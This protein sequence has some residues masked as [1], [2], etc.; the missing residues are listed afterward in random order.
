MTK[1]FHMDSD[2]I[3]LDIPILEEHIPNL[4]IQVD[5]VG[6]AERQSDP[7]DSLTSASG[8]SAAA[9]P[10][11]LPPR[12]AYGSGTL[13]LSIPPIS[14][15]LS[16][17]VTPDESE[18]EPGA[19]TTLSVLVKD[20]DGNPLPD[21][22][23][24]VAV[25]DEAILALTGYRLPDPIQI[26]YSNRSSDLYSVYERTSILLS[27]PLTLANEAAEKGLNLMMDGRG[28][29]GGFVE[30][31]ALPMYS[32][33]APMMDKAAGGQDQISLRTD[34]NPLA[35][36][37]PAARTGL[38]GTARI[39]IQLP[40]NLT[41][42]R[43]MVVAVNP[44]GNKFG[45]AESSLTARLPLMVR[46][47]APRFLN[48]GDRIELPVMIQ[49]QTG[50]SLIVNV[51]AHAVN[52]DLTSPGLQVSVPA[53]DRVEVRFG[54]A[55]AMAGTARIQFAA[56]SGSYSDAASVELPVY[57]PATTESFATYG[58]LD[59]GSFA[60]SVQ[61]PTGV[62]PQFGGLDVT[63]S[64]TALQAL[65]DAVLYLVS[66]PY[67]CSEQLAS[68]ILAISALRDVL[69]AF[70]AEG[71]PSP[72]ELQAAVTRDIQKLA[73]M[74]NSDGG[75]PT[76]RRGF[77][78]NPFNTIHA[79]HA[80]VRAMEKGFT[81]P[82]DMQQNVLIY[83]REVDS[84]Y[85]D[86]YSPE[87]RRTLSAY[88]LYVRNLMGD[89]DAAGAEALLNDA[90]LDGLP[91]QA[92]GWLWPVIDNSLMLD[93]IRV[94]VNNRVVETAG[95]ANFVTSYNDQS[96]LLLSSDRRT[97]AIL[98]DALIGDN[99]DS[100]LIPKLVTGLLENRTRGRWGNTQEN[101]FALLA[102]DRY[103]NTYETETPDFIARLWLGDIYAGSSEFQGRTAELHE[104][105]LPMAYVLSETASGQE[106]LILSKEGSGRLYYR[107]GLSYAPTDLNLDPLEMGFVVR[108]TY[109]AVDDP[110]DVIR[111]AKGV[112]HVR[113]G[114]RVRVLISM[115]ADSRRYHVALVDPLPA[116][117][118]V[119]NPELDVSGSLPDDSSGS[120]YR[121]GW[122]WGPWYEHQNLRDNR[123][124]VFASMLWDGVYKY[125]YFVHATTPGEFVVPPA[126]AEEMYSPEVFGR[127]ASDW[128]VV[129]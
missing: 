21:A 74:Q 87:T 15:T 26:F 35:A 62:F 63:T 90:G 109:E 22:E 50:Q 106:N 37:V 117:F 53:H 95:A 100:D 59:D 94:F 24:A 72:N 68:R 4:E 39:P 56:V 73:G 9:S 110:A 111:D 69:S 28:G 98:L 33:S 78:S 113:A 119:I 49:N 75:F 30:G 2:S 121:Y 1:E 8:S 92:V 101:V 114:A 46:P 14:R 41:R 43:I 44:G 122:W 20:A 47:S 85:P 58:V 18:L 7:Q 120:E 77:E 70:K 11:A 36:F 12:P 66:Y 127:T 103:F 125:S 82:A 32:A 83:L 55:A 45:M 40:D 116:G 42:Y 115:V 60:Q 76:W 27:D 99:P 91:I 123:A 54:A 52:L 31:T 89:R 38:D 108:R 105:H 65:T 13:T 25:V 112:W 84:H 16:L 17:L 79:A 19:E 67:E 88:A 128:V 81:V 97:D 126:K 23:L 3:A 104:T 64:S 129:E 96:Y 93:D 29:G 57:T 61:Y 124:E 118:E 71:L 86:W 102:L 10:N 51:A 48:F 5:L 6:A 34:F 80:L 107:L